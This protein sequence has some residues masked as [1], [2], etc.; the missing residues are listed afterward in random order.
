[1]SVPVV[2]DPRLALAGAGACPFVRRLALRTEVWLPPALFRL[3]DSSDFLVDSPHAR[4]AHEEL[5]LG[6]PLALRRAL[7]LWSRARQ[8]SDFA[9]PGLRWLGESAPQSRLASAPMDIARRFEA[10]SE[11][12]QRDAGSRLDAVFAIDAEVIALALCIDCASILT[13]AHAG[14]PVLV[15]RS[16]AAIPGAR[17]TEREPRSD[18]IAH[19]T[20]ATW[21]QLLTDGGLQAFAWQLP[22]LAMVYPLAPGAELLCSSLDHLVGGFDPFLT[23]TLDAERVDAERDENLS[24]TWSDGL[25]LD[26]CALSPAAVT[27]P[28]ET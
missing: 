15:Q 17:A 20:L 8:R 16:L 14:P 28:Q 11:T 10:L 5:A 1:M 23:Q 25:S 24:E 13:L 3:L 12:Y 26:W 18:P 27:H 7:R 4:S 22:P 6:D 21:R 9:A 2:I 19:A